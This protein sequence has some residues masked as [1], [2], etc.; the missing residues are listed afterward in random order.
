MKEHGTL[1]QSS[2]DLFDERS[3]FEKPFRP[4]HYLG[5][6]L[7]LVND[8][9]NAVE[10]LDPTGGCVCDLF[11]GS[12]TVSRFL[13]LSRPVVSVDIQEYSRVL[14]EAILQPLKIRQPLSDVCK[15]SEHFERLHWALEPLIEYENLS[16]RQALLGNSEA[17]CDL[18]EYG[19]IIGF[20]LGYGKKTSKLYKIMEDVNSR[21]NKHNFLKTSGAIVSRYYGGVYFSYEQAAQMDS[22]LEEIEDYKIEKKVFCQAA[23]LSTASD[24]VNT[25]GKQFAQPLRPRTPEGAPKK[26]L[27]HQVQKD[28]CLEV[29]DLYDKWV[30]R[31][32]NLEPTRHQCR[33]YKMD[34]SDALSLLEEEVKVIYADPPYTRDHYSRFYHVLETLCLRDNPNISYTFIH[35]KRN[36]SRGVYRQERHQSPFCIRSLAPDAFHVLFAKTKKLNCSLILSYSPYNDKGEAHPRVLTLERIKD[37]AGEYFKYIDIIYS[38]KFLH[39]KLNSVD[40]NFGKPERSEVLIVCKN[41]SRGS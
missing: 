30:E 10:D 12:G 33:V 27:G 11:A 2:I 4:I 13:S 5:S 25:I 21:L 23:L 8:I 36:I 37:I 31:Y 35:G 29:F 9:R 14:C 18:I 16:I 26:E 39:S 6:K 17:L 20:A 7:R 28:R 3:H 41:V 32:S 1:I 19:P 22:I 34:Y 38:D 24:L 40:N 15:N